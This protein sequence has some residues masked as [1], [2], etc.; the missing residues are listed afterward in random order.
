M[1]LEEYI[2][3]ENPEYMPHVQLKRSEYVE[4]YTTIASDGRY[5]TTVKV[6]ILSF[7]FGK[8]PFYVREAGYP[9]LYTTDEKGNINKKTCFYV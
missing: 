6:P 9:Q 3:Q 5:L 1:T 2:N 8:D 4:G 7:A